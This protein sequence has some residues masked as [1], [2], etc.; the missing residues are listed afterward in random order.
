MLINK[1]EVYCTVKKL[2]ALL[3][4]CTMCIGLSNAMAEGFSVGFAQI[5]QESGWRDAETASIKE[6]FETA[7]KD[8]ELT[9]YFS[10]AQQKQENQIAAIRNFIAQGVDV[11]GLA[12]VVTT[13][14]GAV[15]QEAKEAGIHIVL[16]DRGVE[17]EFKDLYTCFIGSDFILE[18]EMAADAMAKLLGEKGNVVE[19]QGTV[20][21][22]A[23]IDRQT[24]FKN[25][26]EKDHP[27]IKI[28]ATQSGDFTRAGGKEVM[29]AFLKSY[30]GQINGVYAHNDDMVLGAIEAIKE[31]GLKPSEDIKTVSI[32]GV[33][34]VFEAMVAG[35][36]NVTVECNP[37][38]GPKFLE[39][40]RSLVKGEQIDK[41]VKS[42]D[43]VF[44]AENAAETLPNRKY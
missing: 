32:D 29:E 40:C 44:W 31:A 13:G 23:A 3:L 15:F 14:W 33:R 21:A 1:K 38:L 12:P 4:V 17:P 18:G 36:A 30:P 39:V 9:F 2:I 6:T 41:W 16:L 25:K 42:E 35:E 7:Q 28:I 22:S 26:M 19:L 37:L 27:N 11:I 5:G 34:G 24:G 20:G 8:G 43:G 10:D